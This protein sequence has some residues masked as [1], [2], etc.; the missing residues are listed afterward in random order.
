[1]CA[2][3]AEDQLLLTTSKLVRTDKRV[4][5]IYA[6]ITKKQE[7]G[8][9]LLDEL[10]QILTMEVTVIAHQE[11]KP[12]VRL[13][14]FDHYN[15]ASKVTGKLF[16]KKKKKGSTSPLPKPE[17]KTLIHA[18]ISKHFV[19]VDI[20]HLLALTFSEGGVKKVRDDAGKK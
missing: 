8:I 1:M 7:N 11:L 5:D 10:K 6:I 14:A 19:D 15:L 9:R 18:A 13:C 4:A 2:Q 20:N 16:F 3:F 17:I 12:L